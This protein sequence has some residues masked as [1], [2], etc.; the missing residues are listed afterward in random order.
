MRNFTTIPGLG[1]RRVTTTPFCFPFFLFPLHDNL[2]VS[3]Y[4]FLD[5]TPSVYPPLAHIIYP[6]VL[7]PHPFTLI[8]LF[9]PDP[10]LVSS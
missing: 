1:F 4:S 9:T 2:T 10:L 6:T 8:C 5:L 7:E 3:A